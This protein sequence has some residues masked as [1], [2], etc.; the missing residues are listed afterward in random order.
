MYYKAEDIMG[1]F[2]RAGKY[3]QGVY[4]EWKEI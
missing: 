4:T 3:N 2:V 1:V